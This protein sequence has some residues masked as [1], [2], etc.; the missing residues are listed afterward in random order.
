MACSVG[1]FCMGKFGYI[2]S[3]EDINEHVRQYTWVMVIWDAWVMVV[4]A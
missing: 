4:V 1:N 2:R 3:K